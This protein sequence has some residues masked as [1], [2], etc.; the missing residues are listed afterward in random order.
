MLPRADGVAAGAEEREERA[1]GGGPSAPPASQTGSSQRAPA[2]LLG[3]AVL[4]SPHPHP[5]EER[6]RGWGAASE[7][8]RVYRGKVDKNTDFL[9]MH[10]M[11]GL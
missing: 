9:W 1:S 10:Q 8:T 2:A 4:T 7:D 6:R 11:K 3:T 5:A